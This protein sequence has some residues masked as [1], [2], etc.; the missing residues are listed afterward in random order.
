MSPRI[1]QPCAPKR[2][3]IK[4]YVVGPGKP[5]TV[6]KNIGFLNII[7]LLMVVSIDCWRCIHTRLVV[8]NLCALCV[9][10][11]KIELIL[12]H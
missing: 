3:H 11:N 12:P 2:V 5:I 10:W 7:Q 8:R 1:T 4:Q 9:Q 6:Q